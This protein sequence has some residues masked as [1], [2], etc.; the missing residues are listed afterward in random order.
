VTKANQT[1]QWVWLILRVHSKNSTGKVADTI[2][3]LVSFGSA[4]YVNLF[5]M[6]E[7]FQTGD[8]SIFANGHTAKY[9]RRLPLANNES[10]E[11]VDN[12]CLWPIKFNPSTRLDNAKKFDDSLFATVEWLPKQTYRMMSQHQATPTGD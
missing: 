5:I 8:D 7:I 6:R 1:N 9:Y 10:S 4:K 12:Y 11:V 3:G 2:Y